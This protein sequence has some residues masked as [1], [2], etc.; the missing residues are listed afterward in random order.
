MEAWSVHHLSKAAQSSLDEPSVTHLKAYAQSL[1][2]SGIPVIFTLG[3]LSKIVGVDYSV[4]RMTVE[5]RRESANYRMFAIKKRS[6]GR[7]H[8]HSVTGELLRTQ[9][10]INSEILQ[11]FD[12]H[13]ASFA[14]HPKGGV[15]NCASKHCGA[16]WMFQYDLADFFHSIDESDV[17]SIFSGMGYRPLLAFEMA[18]VCT[19]LR[20][21]KHLMHLLNMPNRSSFGKNYTLYQKVVDVRGF[22][23]LPSPSPMG[24]L[25]QGA[26]TSPMLSNLAAYKLDIE[27][28]EFADNHG[29]IY[30]RYADDLTFSS[31]ENFP[32]EL[33]IGDIHRSVIGI[34]RKNKFIENRKKTRVAGPGSK[35]T[36]L[37]L[38]VDGDL[39]R[40]SK[41]TYKRIDRHLYA[42][43]KYGITA[44]SN[45]EK[46]DTPLGFYNHLAGLVAFVK[47][48]DIQRWNEFHSRFSSINSPTKIN[49]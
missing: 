27:L 36:V 9:Q 39:P 11:K 47:D 46:F 22:G 42:I 32:K 34:I 23:A 20:L 28:T 38:L 4:L 8:I 10:F 7:R 18:R 12:P 17:Y 44:V 26:P 3:H 6:G 2:R 15:R 48:V 24:V 41:E 13:S 40:L 25:P 49:D 30:T 33:S 5:R 31:I 16:R 1:Q 14:F 35:K 37:G 29:L 21:P 43:K 19:T 45:Y